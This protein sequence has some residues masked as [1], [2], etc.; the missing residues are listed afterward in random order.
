M[1][2]E[3][4]S[5]SGAP[6]TTADR[7]TAVA[8]SLKRFARIARQ[9]DHKKGIRAY[10]THIRRDP[11]IPA[12]F[13]VLFLLPTLVTAGYFYLIASDRYI[14]EARFALRPALGN[15]DKV[16]SD[17]TG[18]NSSM[19]KQMIAQDTLIT[20]SYIASRQMVEAMERQMP[21]RDM[22]SRDGIDF[23]SRF[24]ANE[25][26]ELFLRYWRK[27]VTTHVDSNGGIVTLNVA[28]FDPEESYRLAQA[29]MDESERMVNELS[30]RS[31]NAAL[32][33]S[34]RELKNAEERLLTVQRAMRDLRNRAGV[35]DAQ[36][37]NKNNLMVIAELRKKRIELSVQLN[38]SLRDLSPERRPIQD[39][40]AQIQDLDDNIEKI[41]RQMTSTDPDQRRLLSEAM[42]EFEGLENERKNAQLYYNKVLAASEQARIIA[43]RQ[44]EFFTP[45][46]SPVV[47][48]SAIEPRR[49]LITSI[50][51]L[52]A[53][54]VFGL[55]V[56]IR[57]YLYS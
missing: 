4:S 51:A 44:I 42:T 52:V 40:K 36:S 5:P 29:L 7:S 34:T 30:V 56:V 50:V 47:P 27:R 11:W 39:L 19:S 54:A 8:E 10:Q 26:I 1:S 45:V 38:Q 35:L 15:V 32:A 20:I 55:S 9:S 3:I 49:H 28:A 13:L 53:M 22:Y 6:L 24:D 25:P 33:E 43:N 12:L 31:R 23:F 46:V 21:L 16:Q 37:A 14:T 57:K 18:S 2:T 41:E 48:I 17:E